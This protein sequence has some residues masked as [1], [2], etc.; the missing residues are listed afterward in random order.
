M[1]VDNVGILK[2]SYSELGEALGLPHDH[3]IIASHIIQP[4]LICLKVIGPSMPEVEEGMVMDE[5]SLSEFHS[6]NL[7]KQL[8]ELK[9]HE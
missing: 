7:I 4:L 3:K 9:K 2:I 6:R 5:M 8:R 1:A